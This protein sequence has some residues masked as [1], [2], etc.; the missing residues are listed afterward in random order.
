MVIISGLPFMF[1][2]CLV[3]Y[4]IHTTLKVVTYEVSS[5]GWSLLLELEAFTYCNFENDLRQVLVLSC[6]SSHFARL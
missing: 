2:C 4:T 1:S 6:L 3:L 5:K